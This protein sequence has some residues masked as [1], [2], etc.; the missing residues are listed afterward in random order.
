MGRRHGPG[1]NCANMEL[2][3][4]N[5][6]YIYIFR[7]HPD[8]SRRVDVDLHRYVL[9]VDRPQ[10]GGAFSKPCGSALV[11]T[12]CRHGQTVCQGTDHTPACKSVPVLWAARPGDGRRV[13]CCFVCAIDGTST[14]SQLSW[15]SD[16]HN[17]PAQLIDDVHRSRRLE[18]EW[19]FLA[20]G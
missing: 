12:L 14:R 9:R 5:D 8:I 2:S 16:R 17:L 6:E 18:Y 4:T 1:S 19:T 13:D 15:G 10:A 7:F 3:I 20:G 11:S